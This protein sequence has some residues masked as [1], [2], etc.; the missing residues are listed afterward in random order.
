MFHRDKGLKQIDDPLTVATAELWY[1]AISFLRLVKACIHV[2]CDSI[3]LQSPGGGVSVVID[4]GISCV[5]KET[6]KKGIFSRFGHD[7]YVTWKG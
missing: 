7:T 5:T 6:R 4:K 2:N 1:D 3:T